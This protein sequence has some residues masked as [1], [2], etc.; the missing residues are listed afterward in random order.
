MEGRALVWFQELKASKYVG[1][2]EE[3]VRAI[4]IRF[5]SAGERTMIQWKLSL[6]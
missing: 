4:Q 1:D 3:F 6:N 2:W 5:D